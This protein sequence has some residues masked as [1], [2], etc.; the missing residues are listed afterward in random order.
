MRLYTF[1]SS[2]RSITCPLL[3][4]AEPYKIVVFQKQV[5]VS[6]MVGITIIQ[7]LIRLRK[8]KSV[9][10]TGC[11]MNCPL[12]INNQGFNTRHIFNKS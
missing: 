7:P 8:V 12:I 1:S 2:Q 10:D 3:R 9:L 11:D 5:G 6:I 4:I